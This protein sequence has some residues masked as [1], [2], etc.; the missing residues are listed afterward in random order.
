VVPYPFLLVLVVVMIRGFGSW[1]N[2]A[3]H[4]NSISTTYMADQA[5]LH[6]NTI[7]KYLSGAYEPRMSNLIVL[8]TVIAN[9][10]ERSP[11]QLMF[12]A[13]T[14]M[15]EMKMVEARWRKKIKRSS[16]AGRP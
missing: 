3:M 15:D 10:E 1:L 16:E 2:K 14:S 4:R 6:V 9:K 7:N 5:G 13:I 8:V 12:E 11:T